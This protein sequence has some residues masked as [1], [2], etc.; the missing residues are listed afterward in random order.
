MNFN[1]LK[2]EKA[3][4]IC[5]AFLFNTTVLANSG[6]YSLPM[7]RQKTAELLLQKKKNQ[8]LKLLRTYIKSENNSQNKSE[9][10][11]LLTETASIFVGRESQE[12][13]ENSLN[14][15]LENTKEAA[16]S[17]DKCL[18]LEPEQLN[19]LIQKTRLELVQKNKSDADKTISSIKMLVP[20]T[21]YAEWLDLVGTKSQPDFKNKTILKNLPEKNSERS[22]AMIVLELDRSFAAKNYSRA[23]DII[24]YLE[25]NYSEWPDLIYYRYKLNA[26]SSENESDIKNKAEIEPM[27]IYKNKC[28]GLGKTAARK[29]RYDF[30]LCV[31]GE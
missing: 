21:Q 7:L 20:H 25:K 3:A 16:K 30:D 10:I 22:F 23:K 9:A 4:L 2:F 24:V 29:F 12:A 14:L 13:Y 27:M 19:C 18:A 1:F 17:N 5:A 6:Q 11:E 26:E 28:K 8:A 15:I 31:R